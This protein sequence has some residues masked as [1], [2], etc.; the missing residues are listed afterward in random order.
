MFKGRISTRWVVFIV[1]TVLLVAGVKLRAADFVFSL[2]VASDTELSDPN[3][4][5]DEGFDPGDVYRGD[6]TPIVVT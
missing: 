6:I 3:K 4:D 5:G 1:Y 2:D